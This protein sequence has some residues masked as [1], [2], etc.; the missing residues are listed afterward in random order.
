MHRCRCG[1]GG[2]KG[3]TVARLETH[4][5][6]AP[7]KEIERLNRC[8]LNS[9]ADR[10]CCTPVEGASVS[11][12]CSVALRTPTPHLDRPP[13]RVRC[14]ARTHAPSSLQNILL[15]ADAANPL[16]RSRNWRADGDGCDGLHFMQVS[17]GGVLNSVTVCTVGSEHWRG[18][19]SDRI[20][21]AES[22]CAAFFVSPV[23]PTLCSARCP[24]TPTASRGEDR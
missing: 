22:R 16:S 20:L 5:R 6:R 23:A 3:V 7:L 19:L 14:S 15:S 24:S 8:T 9:V 12:D 10:C 13:T 21:I 11:P 1:G 4:T 2:L 17:R 18:S